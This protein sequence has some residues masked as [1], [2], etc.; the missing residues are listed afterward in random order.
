VT[1][2]LLKLLKCEDQ[3]EKINFKSLV[4][5]LETAFDLLLAIH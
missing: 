1:E 3:I 2:E 4:S 5:H